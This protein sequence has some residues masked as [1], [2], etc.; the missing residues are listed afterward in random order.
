MERKIVFA[1][2][3]L[4]GEYQDL[5]VLPERDVIRQEDVNPIDPDGVS[6]VDFYN[7]R[8]NKQETYYY[9]DCE[10]INCG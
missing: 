9:L 1:T 3:N 2:C 6:V 4:E 10:T 5:L 8:T 7:K